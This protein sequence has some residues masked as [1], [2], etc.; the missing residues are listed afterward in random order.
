MKVTS[1]TRRALAYRREARDYRKAGW[2]RCMPTKSM[3]EGRQY[4][5]ARIV[6][7]KIA[8][9]GMSVWVKVSCSGVVQT[10]KAP[11]IGDWLLKK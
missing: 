7:V 8:A 6:D 1:F 4:A 10:L 11:T 5:G 3:R 2:E 9:D